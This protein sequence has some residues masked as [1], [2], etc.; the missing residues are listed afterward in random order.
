MRLFVALDIDAA[1][2]QRLHDF[3][4]EVHTHAP[5]V[6]FVA[7]E[8]FHVTL[9]FLGE[10]ERV[11][12]IERG[13]EAVSGDAIEVSFRGYG[14]FPTADH[15]RVFWAG[16]EATSALQAL[17]SRVDEAMRTI[18]FPSERGPYKPH[19]TLARS[20]SGNPRGGRG[21]RP[22]AKFHVVRQYLSGKTAPEFGTMTAHEFF[23]FE[24]ILSPRGATY[25]K[26]R[27]YPLA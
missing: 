25:R 6:R 19:L 22:D 18:G 7:A 23:L 27:R 14:F 16:I 3:A 10:T 15:P 21:D 12:E 8:T 13:L 2:R 24:S 17:A 4:N 11:A 20:G 5:E 9:K 26:V 1:I